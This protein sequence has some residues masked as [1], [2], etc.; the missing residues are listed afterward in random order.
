MPKDRSRAIDEAETAVAAARGD[1]RI[2]E[3]V[4]WLLL[5]FAASLPFLYDPAVVEVA[6]DLR[7]SALHFTAGLAGV[8]LTVRALLRGGPRVQRIPAIAALSAAFL[9]AAAAGVALSADPLLGIAPLKTLI[10]LMV[11]SAATARVWDDTFARRLL[12]ALALPLVFLA[13]LGAAQYLEGSQPRLEPVPSTGLGSLTGGLAWLLQHYQQ[14]APPGTTFT[15]KNLAAS[16]AGMLVPIVLALVLT[17][18]HTAA[19]VGAAALLV[20]A[21]SLIVLCHARATW[22]ALSVAIV[23]FAI[24]CRPTIVGKLISLRVAVL[25]A[26]LAVGGY[27]LDRQLGLVNLAVNAQATRDLFESRLAYNLNG[28]AMVRDHPIAGVGLGNFHTTYP[29]YHDAVIATPRYAYDLF[30]R[31]QHAHNDILQAFI[32]NGLLGGALFVAILCCAIVYA[33]KVGARPANPRDRRTLLL[34]MSLLTLLVNAL[35]DFPLQLPTA[36]SIAA[37]LVGGI[38]SEY[39]AQA[40]PAGRVCWPMPTLATVGLLAMLAGAWALSLVDDWRLRQANVLLKQFVVRL[41]GG[42]VD[43]Q[44]LAL[45]EAAGRTYPYDARV[46]NFTGV[47]YALASV[48]ADLRIEKIEA[49]VSRDP[50]GPSLLVALANRYLEVGGFEPPPTRLDRETA[51]RR[52]EAIW[53]RLRRVAGF[54]PVTDAIGGNLALFRADLCGAELLFRRALEKDPGATAAA[55]GLATIAAYRARDAA[56]REEKCPTDPAPSPDRSAPAKP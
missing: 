56:A 41:R 39:L 54:S 42:P 2:V 33:I 27:L 11:L 29:Q 8:L 32:E 35:A 26:M 17:S 1:G 51:L 24:A 40:P 16:W 55:S 38:V 45:I 19:R 28:L 36:P 22:V 10:S 15:N 23:G 3:A 20:L 31:P 6:A 18:R 14:T 30:L 44:A 49:A 34:G 50:W 4:R 7:A 47:A 43:D 48:P 5:L 53:G 46:A 25:V 12:W 13:P 9:I 37:L 21:L 52:A